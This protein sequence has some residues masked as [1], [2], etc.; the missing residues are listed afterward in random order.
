MAGNGITAQE[1]IEAI[2]GSGGF[3]TEIAK[4]LG[5]SRTHVYR[6]RDKYVSVAEA[7]EDEREKQKD[8]A[9]GQLLKGINSGNMTAII[10]FLKCQAKE[11]GYVERQELTGADGGPVVIKPYIGFTPDEWDKHGDDSDD[12]DGS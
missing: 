9:E 12:D 5:V 6:L 3:V 7:I 8:F 4:R 2:R 11:R 1:A 10:F